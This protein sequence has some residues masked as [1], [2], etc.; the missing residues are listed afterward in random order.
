MIFMSITPLDGQEDARP[1]P[2]DGREVL[3]KQQLSNNRMM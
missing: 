1:R 3:A 2:E